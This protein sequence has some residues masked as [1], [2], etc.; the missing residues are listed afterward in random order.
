MPFATDTPLNRSTAALTAIV[1]GDTVMLDP[2]TSRY[3]GLES[4]GARIWDLLATP[5]T[6]EQL[7]AALTAEYDV[8]PETCQSEVIDF[9]E[10]L[11]AAGLVAAAGD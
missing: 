7:V 9:L 2:E 11:D 5:H 1:D 8:D 10:V 6:I 3:F 4:T